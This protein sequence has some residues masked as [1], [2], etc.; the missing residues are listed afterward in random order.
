[1]MPKL[2]SKSF[3]KSNALSI[4]HNHLFNSHV[5]LVPFTII[6]R[7]KTESV[8]TRM[9]VCPPMHPGRMLLPPSSHRC[10]VNRC[11]SLS[12]DLNERK[13]EENPG[14]SFSIFLVQ[15]SLAWCCYCVDELYKRLLPSPALWYHL[16]DNS[17]WVSPATHTPPKA[18][19]H[20]SHSP[21][22][23]MKM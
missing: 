16:R 12:R 8:Y 14:E 13:K 1:M 2:L 17:S 18:Q 21:K 9:N 5:H 23:Q 22:T 15:V 7:C 6:S 3:I 19:I 20:K 11:L 4:L 10:D